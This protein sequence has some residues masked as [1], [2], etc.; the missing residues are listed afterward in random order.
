MPAGGCELGE[1]SWL[2]WSCCIVQHSFGAPR[3][4]CP[5]PQLPSGEIQNVC[6]LGCN[7]RRFGFSLSYEIRN[8]APKMWSR[9]RGNPHPKFRQCEEVSGICT[10]VLGLGGLRAAEEGDFF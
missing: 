2:S 8:I 9:T 5:E 10:Q 1:G 7:L 3:V 4:L 6:S